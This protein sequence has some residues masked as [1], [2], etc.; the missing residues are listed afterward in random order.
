MELEGAV[1]GLYDLAADV[2]LRVPGLL[3]FLLFAEEL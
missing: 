1:E 2:E 3:L